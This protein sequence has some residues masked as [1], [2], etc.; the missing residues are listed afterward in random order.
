MLARLIPSAALALL[1]VSGCAHRPPSLSDAY[2]Q[3]L[4]QQ[5]RA[6]LAALGARD[7]AQTAAFFA[8]DATLHVAGMPPVQGRPAVERF[9]GN[10]FRFM[11]ASEA[12]PEH[13]R[14]SSAGDM[15]YSVGRVRNA[16]GGPEGTVE[17]AGKY[18]LVWE[19]REGAWRIVLY[20]VSNDES[21][22]RP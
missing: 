17:Y 22:A 18:L 10:V 4:H 8:E 21:E 1:L 5:E 15:A 3:V 7:A 12:T 2:R 20:G 9:Y 19:K 14:I 16:F 6:F 13:T 11:R